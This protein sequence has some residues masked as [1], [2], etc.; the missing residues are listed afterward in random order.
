MS[1]IT[2][3]LTSIS[4]V[5]DRLGISATDATRDAVFTS[6]IYAV[7]DYIE[8]ACGGV[9]FKRSTF[10]QELY[11][12]SMLGDFNPRLPY[13][14]LNNGPLISI[15]SFQ[16]RTGSRSNPTWVDF[17]AD[18]Y[19]PMLDSAMI[20]VS[21]GLPRGLQNI[22]IT[23]IAGYLI[24]FTDEYNDAVHTLP[25]DISDLCERLVTKLI[26]RR[27]SEGRSQ[28]SFN[29]SSINWGAYL[30]KHDEA[31]LANYRRQFLA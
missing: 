20:Y 1:T 25:H 12:G 11:N 4:K 13:L 29:N 23:Y 10:T 31:I 18:D 26:K 19:E 30:E 28:E 9:R 3:A 5:K 21:G 24:D 15:S 22:R 6:M 27:E 2:Y 16:Y 7:T 17:G 14:I 8:R